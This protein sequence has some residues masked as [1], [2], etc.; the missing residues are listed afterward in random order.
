MS[1]NFMGKVKIENFIYV[2]ISGIENIDP[3]SGER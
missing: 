1:L 3:Y 2:K